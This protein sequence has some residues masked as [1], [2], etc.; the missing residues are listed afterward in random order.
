MIIYLQAGAYTIA[1]RQLFDDFVDRPGEVGVHG[2]H[3]IRFGGIRERCRR[4]LPHF[5]VGVFQ[6]HNQQRS[7]IEVSQFGESTDCVATYGRI[8]LQ[9]RRKTCSRARYIVA[10]QR[11]RDGDSMGMLSVLSQ[12]PQNRR[13]GLGI[14]L[15]EPDDGGF[16]QSR[17]VA[18]GTL[19]QQVDGSCIAL[20]GD[21]FCAAT[22]TI[23][24]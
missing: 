18:V 10:M 6:S 19:P 2:V 22:C 3:S 7:R 5:R 8:F 24:G 21:G 15:T 16:C 23:M 17:I 14:Q 4:L 11:S 13:C 1:R 9:N 12:S 20:C